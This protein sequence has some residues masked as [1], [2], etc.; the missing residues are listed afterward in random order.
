MALAILDL[1]EVLNAS[2][3]ADVLLESA[4]DGKSLSSSDLKAVRKWTQEDIAPERIFTFP[5]LAIDTAPTRNM[6]QYSAESQKASVK[7]WIGKT[8]LFN[9]NGQADTGSGADHR[10]AAASQVARI[11]RSQLV[12]TPAGE[13]GTL[14]WV[15]TVRGV[16]ESIDEFI[17]K[18][19]AG[20]LRE[21][22]IHVMVQSVDCSICGKSM[23]DCEAGHM[24][25]MKYGRELCVMV[26]NGP[27]EPI[28][29][30]SVA[31]PGSVNAHVMNDSAVADYSVLS[32]REALGGNA[33]ALQTIA[34]LTEKN[35]LTQEELAEAAR[36]KSEEDEAAKVKTEEDEAAKVKAE[37]DEAAKAKTEE[38]E[39]LKNAAGDPPENT[40]AAKCAKCGKEDCEC[41]D[42][43][44]SVKSKHFLFEGACPACGRDGA[45]A[46]AVKTV[47]DATK[48]LREE[49]QSQ[50]TAIV[51]VANTK[52]AA[53]ETLAAANAETVKQ[54]DAIV[55]SIRKE[56][57]NLAITNGVKAETERVL[58]T[59][60]LDALNYTAVKALHEALSATK[61]VNVR[62]EAVRQITESSQDRAR[63]EFGETVIV[64]ENG[65]TKTRSQ[66][67]PR[68]ASISK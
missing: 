59:E 45:H 22:S 5:V 31:C 8:F 11:Y 1:K 35:M 58:Y 34:R 49:M 17:A 16:S 38:D 40:E 19:E 42:S 37:E 56:T 46:E 30:S 64:T 28:E 47:E 61:P 15:Y 20:I 50:V 52:I 43:A 33:S 53:A 51:E 55:K 39:A 10:L 32:L 7:A 12:K 66:A 18:I 62:V 29:L 63:R 44:E 2:V 67:R 23:Q 27:L 24:P 13:T 3:G 21:V 26:T 4:A 25:G 14:V 57:V 41:D 54:F 60:E 6:V 9:S 36:V 68:F 65:A 48:E